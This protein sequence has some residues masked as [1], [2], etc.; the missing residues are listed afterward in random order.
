M[1]KN[2]DFIYD[3]TSINYYICFYAMDRYGGLL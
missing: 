1:Q 3:H 2:Q